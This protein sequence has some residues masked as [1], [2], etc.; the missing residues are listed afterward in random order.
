MEILGKYRKIRKLE[1]QILEIRNIYNFRN[2][3]KIFKEWI[4]REM[5]DREMKIRG[6]IEEQ[7]L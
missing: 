6:K 1:I 7:F 2:T 5:K 3:I 4:D